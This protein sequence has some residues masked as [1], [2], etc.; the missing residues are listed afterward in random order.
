MAEA[1]KGIRN[2]DKVYRGQK[3][4]KKLY[5]TLV[6]YLKNIIKD[7]NEEKF[8][9]INRENKGFNKRV[10]KVIGGK[11]MIKLFGFVL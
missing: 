2:I 3:E 8:R 11:F 4:G 9:K 5:K 1:E 6:L 7:P 10:V